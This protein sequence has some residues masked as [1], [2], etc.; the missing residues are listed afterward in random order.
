MDFFTG[1]IMPLAIGYA[2]RQMAACNGQLIPVMQNQALFT[3][4]GTSFGGNGQPNGNFGLPNM[5]GRTAVGFGNSGSVM[6]LGTLGGEAS[7]TLSVNEMPQHTH[8]LNAAS[9]GTLDVTPEAMVPG[10]PAGMNIYGQ[11]DAVVPLGGMPL[12]GQGGGQAHPN[13]QPSLPI[14]FAI[15]LYGI[16]PTRS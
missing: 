5:Q 11:A 6:P 13:M 9:Q 16:F 14:T 7:H 8:G 15:V 4:L 1:Q 12:A 3:L 10:K 2:P